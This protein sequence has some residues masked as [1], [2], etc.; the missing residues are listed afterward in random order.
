MA[1]EHIDA[2]PMRG[3]H[4][5]AQPPI[6]QPL[7]SFGGDHRAEGAMQQRIGLLKT[8][9]TLDLRHHPRADDLTLW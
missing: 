9:Q 5:R 4:R 3:A 2:E 7:A 6:V 1:S 8:G